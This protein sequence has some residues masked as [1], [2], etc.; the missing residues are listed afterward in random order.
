MNSARH[1]LVYH[2]P[3]G[4]ADGTSV[5]LRRLYKPCAERLLHLTFRRGRQA[6]PAEFRRI[7][8]ASELP[9]PFARGA[10]FVR[11]IFPKIAM[12]ALAAS[13]P[14]LHRVRNVWRRSPAP[15]LVCV[16]SDDHAARAR[17]LLRHAGVDRYVLMLMDLLDEGPVTPDALPELFALARDASALITVSAQLGDELARHVSAPQLVLQP[18]CGFVPGFPPDR[19]LGPFRALATGALYA[20]RDSFF[21]TVFLPGWLAF[22]ARRPAA[23]LLYI[24]TEAHKLSPAARRHV[25]ELGRRP[26]AEFSRLLASAS[27]G[28]LPV[29]HEAASRWRFSVPGRLADYLAA[30]LPIVAPT[31]PGTATEDFL[32]GLPA[33]VAHFAS[34]ATEVERALLRLHDERAERRMIAE[35]A[36]A[37]AR[38]HLE[39]PKTRARFFDWLRRHTAPAAETAALP[40]VAW[41]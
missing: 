21:E 35:T 3:L 23:E 34:T 15:A 18:P 10:R 26:A 6:P 37:F 27:V 4:E 40:S 8:V 25:R 17:V 11:R 30:G 22:V 2:V 19:H 16:Y 5:M 7:H 31:C 14:Q 1:L 9:W 38:E 39:L 29:R 20:G 28:V 36:V 12:P 13:S 33:G 24:G 41:P 32:A